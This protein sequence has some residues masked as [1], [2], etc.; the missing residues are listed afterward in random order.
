MGH[1]G[2]R[3]IIGMRQSGIQRG[4]RKRTELVHISEK[5]EKQ[6]DAEG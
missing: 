1:R 4:E 2:L 5:R 6:W 3:G